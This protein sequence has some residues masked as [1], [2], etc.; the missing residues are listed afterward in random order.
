M[1]IANKTGFTLVDADGNQHGDTVMVDAAPL[2]LGDKATLAARQQAVAE[3]TDAARAQVVA[4][5]D[6]TLEKHPNLSL[7]IRSEGFI[8]CSCGAVVRAL[9]DCCGL[10]YPKPAG[11]RGS[12]CGRVGVNMA[13]P[14]CGTRYTYHPVGSTGANPRAFYTAIAH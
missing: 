11:A 13:C 1:F 5:A 9:N 3:A 14:R 12:C 8:T 10:C 4:R 6:A 7:F 2:E